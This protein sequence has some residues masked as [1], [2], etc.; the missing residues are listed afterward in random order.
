MLAAAFAKPLYD[1]IRMALQSDLYS[2]IL[3]VPF[4]SAY[5]VRTR[6]LNLASDSGPAWRLALMPL[7]AGLAVL[8]IYW[9]AVHAGWTPA[10]ED[11]L[12]LMVL[13]FLCFL[14]AIGLTDLGVRTLEQVAFPAAFLLFLIPFPTTVRS[15]IETFFQY[16]SADAAH[17]F[18]KMF[19]MP[20]IRR[21]LEF[22]LPGFALQVAPQCSGIHSSLVLFITSLIA[23]YLFLK[24][25][26]RRWLL[27]LAVVPLALLRNGFRVFVIGELCVNVSP[28]MI[29]SPIHHHGGP[30]FF[31]LSLIPFFLLLYLLRRSE[32]KRQRNN[33]ERTI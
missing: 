7:L 16:G 30:I 25:S 6:P 13:A 32:L 4:I 27:S 15:A 10:R 1:L 2:H 23:G 11:Y 29:D 31:A 14:T 12:A 5:L 24:T 17:M 18:F 21:G 9:S 28:E 26:S 33:N 22:Q 3:L 19:G 20:L 8:G